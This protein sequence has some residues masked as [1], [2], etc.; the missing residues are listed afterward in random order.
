MELI[1][2]SVGD[3]IAGIVNARDFAVVCVV[4]FPGI[5]EVLDL[6]VARLAALVIAHHQRGIIGRV[7][8]R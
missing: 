5:A 8:A 2:P 4:A 7:L 3:R 1:E 6:F